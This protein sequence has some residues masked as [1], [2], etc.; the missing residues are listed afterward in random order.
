MTIKL[1]VEKRSG[2][3][4]AVRAAGKIP[5]VV[6]G[7]KQEPIS[8]AV[9]RTTFTKVL[10]EAGESTILNLIGL[11]HDIEVLIH[12][13]AFNA[14]QGGIEHAD[15]YAI[16]RGK[17]LTTDV[18][19]EFVGEAP[20]LKSGATLNKNLHEVEVTCRPSVLPSHIEVDVSIL[21]DVDQHIAVKDLVVPTGVKIETDP[22]LMIVTVS[23]ARAAEPEST[24]ESETTEA[25]PVESTSATE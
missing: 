9:D 22:E 10:D 6:Y 12:D 24:P 2:S 5:A 18:A 11:E 3:V 25:A 13:V 23:G 7:P 21:T 1:E 20:I 14:A 4:N 15:F 16:E 8:L 17:E 19:L